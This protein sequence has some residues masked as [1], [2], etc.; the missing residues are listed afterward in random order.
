MLP[1]LSS[2]LHIFCGIL[3]VRLN[4]SRTVLR[5]RLTPSSRG[6]DVLPLVRVQTRSISI[7]IFPPLRREKQAETYDGKA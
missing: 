3:W 7:D 6:T 5:L 4:S 2:L 1:L